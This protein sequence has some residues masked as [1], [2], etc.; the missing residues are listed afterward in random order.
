MTLSANPSNGAST[1]NLSFTASDAASGNSNVTAAE[2]WIDAGAAQPVTVSSPA[3]T[4]NLNATIPAGLSAGTHVISVRAQDAFGNWGEAATIDLS[5]D[6][7]GP[8]TSG[9]SAAP[10]PNNGSLPFNT[11][12]TAVRV[13]ASF[14]DTTTG[15]SNVVTAEGFIDTYNASL[16]G[17]GFV[18]VAN[19]GNFNSPAEAG[20]ADVPLAVIGTLSSGN[21]TIYVHAKDAAGN[22][23][24]T[25]TT[26]LVI[27]KVAPTVLSINRVDPSPT[28]AA[29]VNF[30]VTFS[31]SVAGG[32][33]SNFSLV[34]GGGLTGASITSVS[35]TGATRTVTVSTGSGGGTLGLNLTSPTGI[36]DIAGNTLSSSGLPF[37]GQVYTL[38]TPPLYF[39][40]AGTTNPPGVSGSADDADIYFWNGAAFSRAI[41][42]SVAPYSLP[43]G[44]NV[45]GFDQS[46]CNTVLYVIQWLGRGARCRYCS[47]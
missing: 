30:L 42:V 11:S 35:G 23:G 14:A 29:S 26:T 1:V 5:I 46:Q 41:D 4:R 21:H 25:A 8:L 31:E 37:V 7:A 19:D 40:T 39:S 22:W 2:F 20:F 9:V 13:T 10:N 44:A 28:S 36:S 45:D 15:N 17:T 38:L 3:P 43:S 33:S 47:G 34:Q 18:F 32:D 24:A 27:D 6:T 16:N 12:V